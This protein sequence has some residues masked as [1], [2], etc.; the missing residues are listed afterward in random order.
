MGLVTRWET[1]L[2]NPEFGGLLKRVGLY[3]GNILLHQKAAE[4]TEVAA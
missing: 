2:S 1:G 4:K 3:L